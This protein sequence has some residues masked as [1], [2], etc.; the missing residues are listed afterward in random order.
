M[1]K[2]R[3]DGLFVEGAEQ[4][5]PKP[6]RGG[7]DPTRRT[8]G[9]AKFHVAPDGVGFIS[10]LSF[11]KR[12]ARTELPRFWVARFQ[13]CWEEYRAEGDCYGLKAGLKFVRYPSITSFALS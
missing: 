5:G 12:V 4:N 10:S 8:S 1:A 11:Y 7:M 2:S 9:Q 13:A 6:R 3:R